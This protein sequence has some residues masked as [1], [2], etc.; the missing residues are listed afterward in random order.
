MNGLSYEEVWSM[1]MTVCE[2]I[3]PINTENLRKLGIDEISPNP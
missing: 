1:V 2:K 3:P